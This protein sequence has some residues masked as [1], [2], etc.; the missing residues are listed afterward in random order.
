MGRWVRTGPPERLHELE[1][2]LLLDDGGRSF[3]LRAARATEAVDLVVT[4]FASSGYRVPLAELS[5]VVLIFLMAAA[6]YTHLLLKDGHFLV[7]CAH[8]RTTRSFARVLCVCHRW[9]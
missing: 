6:V 7:R 9:F 4:D 2:A 3:V 8:P 1:Q 5:N